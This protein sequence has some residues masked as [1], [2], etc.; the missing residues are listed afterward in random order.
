MREHRV[1][2]RRAG[3]TSVRET[4]RVLLCWSAQVNVFLQKER[5]VSALN[6]HKAKE[7]I[8]IILTSLYSLYYTLNFPLD[9]DSQNVSYKNSSLFISISFTP[10][11]RILLFWFQLKDFQQDK[12]FIVA[13]FAKQ[14][15][16][17]WCLMKQHW[18][19]RA[20]QNKKC[21]EVLRIFKKKPCR[22]WKEQNFVSLQ[23]VS[24]CQIDSKHVFT[25]IASSEMQQ[26]TTQYFKETPSF[27]FF[28]F[29]N[30]KKGIFSS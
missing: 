6:T 21:F 5:K 18:D 28:F 2:S 8:P 9:T 30:G 11:K 29:W 24:S 16:C 15:L 23:T 27:T 14:Y 20:V 1:I 26:Y 12:Y 19:L 22:K 4:R 13:S 3:A 25:T 10:R 17:K 7:H